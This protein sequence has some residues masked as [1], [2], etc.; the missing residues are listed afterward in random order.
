MLQTG[1][2][3]ATGPSI[4]AKNTVINIGGDVTPF[5]AFELAHL[6][7]AIVEKNVIDGVI[8]NGAGNITATE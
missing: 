6:K 2:D 1:I 5:N 7:S 3:G 8:T 4:I